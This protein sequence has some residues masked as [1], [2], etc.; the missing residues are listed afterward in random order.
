MQQTVMSTYF[1][2]GRIDDCVCP[3]EVAIAFS[4][5]VNNGPYLKIPANKFVK[6]LNSK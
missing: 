4:E 6:L 1:P 2:L 3:S 5:N